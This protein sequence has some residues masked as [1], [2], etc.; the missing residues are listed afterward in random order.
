MLFSLLLL[1]AH[2]GGGD[3]HHETTKFLVKMI[4]F[5]LSLPT[6]IFLLEVLGPLT[7]F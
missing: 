6:S 4:F 3:C 7:M 5:F 2:L 1:I